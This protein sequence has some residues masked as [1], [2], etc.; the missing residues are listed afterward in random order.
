MSSPSPDFITRSRGAPVADATQVG[1]TAAEMAAC[2]KVRRL[3]RGIFGAV[4]LGLLPNGKF[5]AV[6]EI[7]VD[8]DRSRSETATKEDELLRRLSH[9]NIAQY[10]GCDWF[11]GA[12]PDGPSLRIF[13]EFAPIGSLRYIV[14]TVKLTEPQVISYARQILFGLK[15]LHDQGVV[16]CE[17]KCDNILVDA[18]GTAK[19]ADF[20][21]S[22]LIE[23]LA[24]RSRFDCT[25]RGATAFWMAPE[26]LRNEAYETKAD[27]WAF[28]C[29]VVEM[30]NRGNVCSQ[31]YYNGTPH[32]ATVADL[33]PQNPD[34]AS[35]LCRSFLARCL[36]RDARDRAAVDELLAHPWISRS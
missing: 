36:V 29:T 10:F 21:C 32:I 34:D 22:K 5:V 11:N 4:H 1:L 27:I 12:D 17:I 19:L 3:G 7:F 20:G 25:T 6:K 13:I 31:L 33:C 2:V 14:S 30:L 35:E 16:H 28:G 8:D 24:G 23:A 9:P 26:V 18:A 15:Y